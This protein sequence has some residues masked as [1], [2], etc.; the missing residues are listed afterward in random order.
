MMILRLSDVA[1]LQRAVSHRFSVKVHFCDSCGGQS[2]TIDEPTDALRAFIADF[3]A[4]KKLH[5]RFS[6]SGERFTVTEHP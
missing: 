3:F 4:A 6:E 2:F 5:V 1:E